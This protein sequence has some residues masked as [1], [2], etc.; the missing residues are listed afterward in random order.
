MRD[1]FSHTDAAIA[2]ETIEHNWTTDAAMQTTVILATQ[3][4]VCS[5][6][7]KVTS[8]FWSWLVAWDATPTIKPYKHGGEPVPACRLV[9]YIPCSKSEEYNRDAYDFVSSQNTR[10]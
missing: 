8:Q 10:S 3:F 6:N 7:F 1:A 4:E 5:T 2:P 9:P